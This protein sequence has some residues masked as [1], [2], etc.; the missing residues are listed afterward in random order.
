MNDYRKM[1]MTLG[2]VLVSAFF[3]TSLAAIP[4]SAQAQA[5]NSALMGSGGLS[6]GTVPSAPLNLVVDQGPGFNWLW[7]D[8]PA[9]QGSDL[10]KTYEIFRGETSGGESLH[11]WAYVG[12]TYHEGTYL[13][14]VNFFN[15]TTDI[16][17]DTE[18]FYKIRAVSDAGN[19]PFSNTASATPSLTGSAPDAPTVI[20]T[21]AVYSAQLSWTTPG[22]PAGSPPARFFFLYRDPGLFGFPS[23][24]DYWMRD[25]SY[26]DQA[27][28]FTRIGE[29]YTYTVRAVNTYGEGEPGDADVTLEGTGNIPSAPR[30]L[31]GLGYNHTVMLWW[32][33]PQNPS[34]IGFDTFE[35][36]RSTNSGGPFTKINETSTFYGYGGFY[37]DNGL[38]NG[39][40]YY[41]EVKA[42]NTNGPSGFSNIA[43]ATPM[44]IPPLPFEVAYLNAYP[45]NNQV[46]L[47]WAY[48]YTATGYDIYRSE[49]T[50][51]ETILTSVGATT[52]YF[53]TSAL[54]GH[55]YFYFVKP[56]R[57]ATIG[58]AS[59]EDSASPSTG[60][61]PDAPT[62]VGATPKE[63]GVEV[64]VPE[65]TVSSILIGFE[66]YR[67]GTTPGTWDKIVTEQDIHFGWSISYT[68]TDPIPD[69][70]YDYTVK[71]RNLYGLSSSSN[72][73]TSFA[74][75]TGDRP[76]P[77]TGLSASG[78]PGSV[79][80]QWS[81]PYFG[82]A[83][84][85][86]YTIERNDSEG[87]WD[88]MDW[89]YLP[90]TSLQWDDSFAIPGVTYQYR[91]MVE[92]NYG[93]A[94]SYSNVVS[95][96]ATSAS[97][98]PSA[99]RSLV[100]TDGIG[101]IVLTWLAPTSQGSSAI[102]RYDIYRGT[103]S[104]GEGVTPIANVPAGT[105]T[106]TDTGLAAGTYYYVVK[107]VN[108]VGSSPASNEDSGAFTPSVVPAAPG[109]L[110]A[111]G[112]IGY[113]ILTWDEPSSGSSPITRYDVFRGTSPG[114]IGATPIG[115][116]AAGTLTYND[117]TVTNGVTYYY[118]VKAVNGQ[119]SSAASNTA[120]A[121][122]PAPSPPNPPRNLAANGYDG[123]VI[124]TWDV[125]TSPGTSAITRYDVFRGTSAG[126]IGATPIGNVAAGVLTYNDSTVTNSQTYYY[127]VKAVNS[128]GSS[129]ASNTAQATPSATGTAPGAPT[130]LVAVGH[131][132]YIQLSWVE[133]SNVGS[134]V[135]NYLIY[136]GT[137][138]GGEDATP[139]AT[140]SGGSL[141]YTDN[142]ATPD[143]PYYY[144]V[145][146]SN[147]FGTSEYSNEATGTAT[148]ETPGTPSA[149][150]NLLATPGK[151]KVTLTW[152]APA[153]D[154]GSPITG[155]KVYRSSGGTPTL[156]NTLGASTLTYED[157][158]GTPGTVYSYS[159]V[160]TNAN[161]AGLETE[162]VNAASQ[163]N[164]G[165]GGTDN[166]MLLI[167][168]GVVV[169]VLVLAVLLLMMMRRKPRR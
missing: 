100:A 163:E 90:S 5:D 32:D 45:G 153:S 148:S 123:Y 80:L 82:T 165:G 53:D 138:S 93:M 156:L 12:A 46:L 121:T 124:L 150:Q 11:D 114:S 145:K 9:S 106:Y 57:G 75:P 97:Q 113:V 38:T 31:T 83:N 70:N 8:H 117:T 127:Q 10:I 2:V 20:G 63:V 92:N 61:P 111:V 112:H 14:G 6:A 30:N 22:V 166:T 33:E 89:L 1:I 24:L 133:P 126:S 28:V 151:G 136:R 162:P 71:L 110:V 96:T 142:A 157:T 74:S 155:Y 64:F 169:V 91:I 58:P 119:G 134:G 147:S 144:K 69:V 99:P 36:Y 98:A 167:G 115:N 62:D 132:G 81:A 161:G 154:G 4:M 37:L 68:D 88:S 15:D 109:N 104:G 18:Y 54:N 164:G 76:E 21:N 27:G 48:T 77:I 95:G 50:G 105:L 60:S 51:T 49:S 102:T 35:I 118:Q 101:Q 7:W 17:L 122:P 16:V 128:V 130:S 43:D 139:L 125:P 34:E 67:N 149:P 26:T 29:L 73:A 131:V 135:A 85:L 146:A 52:T 159:V 94:S 87:G 3:L 129:A 59:P 140:I 168:A 103:T 116:V 55:T 86:A 56:T 47:M 23:L 65:R 66:V 107:A 42:V 13:G 79:R 152:Q 19:G 25:T 72:V 40:T 137:T 78:Q 160:A 143:V 39:Q 108:S 158:T 141:S 44:E 84:L 41:Y 120:Q